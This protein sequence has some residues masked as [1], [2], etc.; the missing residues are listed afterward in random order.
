LQLP[1]GV[2]GLPLLELLENSLLIGLLIVD[3]VLGVDQ[4]RILLVQLRVWLVGH[5]S[6][7]HSG[8][9]VVGQKEILIGLRRLVRIVRSAIWLPVRLGVIVVQVTMFQEVVPGQPVVRIVLEAA[10]EEVQALQ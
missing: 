9:L 8:G 2:R 3:R 4:N 10:V 6:R 7:V 5:E 1:L